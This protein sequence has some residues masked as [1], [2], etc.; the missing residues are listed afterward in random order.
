MGPSGEG[1]GTIRE[2]VNRGGHM[3]VGHHHPHF[4]RWKMTTWQ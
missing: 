2:K 3:F 4:S 1:A